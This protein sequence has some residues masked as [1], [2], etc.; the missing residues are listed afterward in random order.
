V[1]V[2][3]LYATH[4]AT[5]CLFPG[6]WARDVTTGDHDVGRQPRIKVCLALVLV[7]GYATVVERQ[8]IGSVPFGAKGRGH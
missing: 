5:R 2:S 8:G 1:F 6:H 3:E 7:V 4:R